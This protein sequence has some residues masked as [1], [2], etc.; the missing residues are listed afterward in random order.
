MAPK[1][2]TEDEDRLVFLCYLSHGEKW[3]GW[4]DLLPDRTS[5]AIGSRARRLGLMRSG[6]KGTSDDRH[7]G[8]GSTKVPDPCEAKVIMLMKQGLTPSEIDKR[9]HWWPNTTAR[10]LVEMWGRED[11]Q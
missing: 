11:E 7:Y 5:E 6:R 9:M 1:P 2:W 3:D 4:H 10:V 8:F